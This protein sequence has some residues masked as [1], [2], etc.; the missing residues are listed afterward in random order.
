MSTIRLASPLPDLTQPVVIDGYAE[1]GA[2][3]NTAEWTSDARL[4]VELTPSQGTLAHSPRLSARGSTVRGLVVN[5]FTDGIS[6]PVRRDREHRLGQ[7]PGHGR[8]RHDPQGQRPRESGCS[9]A[10][11][12]TLSAA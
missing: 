5:G 10:P 2:T 12:T 3:R 6:S 9:P 11:R 4:L 8:H 7:L 1:G